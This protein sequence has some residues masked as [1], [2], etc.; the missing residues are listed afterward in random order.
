MLIR[1]GSI[2]KEEVASLRISMYKM[3]TF[4]QPAHQ[5]PTKNDAPVPF[6]IREEVLQTTHTVCLKIPRIKILSRQQEL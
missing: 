1:G 6:Q 5:A 4:R 2:Q 3:R